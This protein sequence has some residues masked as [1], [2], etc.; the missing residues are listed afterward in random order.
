MSVGL[1]VTQLPSFPPPPPLAIHDH[2]SVKH[3]TKAGVTKLSSAFCVSFSLPHSFL[4][5]STSPFV[6]TRTKPKAD[7]QRLQPPTVPPKRRPS[8]K[9]HHAPREGGTPPVSTQ[10]TWPWVH[11]KAFGLLMGLFYSAV[12]VRWWKR[13]GHKERNAVKAGRPWQLDEPSRSTVNNLETW[14]ER[15]DITERGYMESWIYGQNRKTHWL[16]KENSE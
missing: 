15:A 7:F 10:H 11:L 1:V 14:R 4:T 12:S 6:F 3:E 9:W 5:W 13:S 2:S 8:P 16:S